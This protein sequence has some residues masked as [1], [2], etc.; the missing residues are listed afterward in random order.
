MKLVL[1]SLQIQAE[2]LFQCLLS[3]HLGRVQGSPLGQAFAFDPVALQARHF[4]CFLFAPPLFGQRTILLEDAQLAKG[5]ERAAFAAF[6]HG[7]LRFLSQ[8]DPGQIRRRIRAR[9]SR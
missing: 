4:F 5:D 9:K 8:H 3:R 7:N 1:G 6:L 2:L